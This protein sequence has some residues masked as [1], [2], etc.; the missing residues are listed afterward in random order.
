MNSHV[1]PRCRSFGSA[2]VRFA[3]DDKSF[4]IDKKWHTKTAPI[5]MGLA[6]FFVLDCW[7]D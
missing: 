3:Q 7:R 1:L 5:L 4:L 6:L 2:E